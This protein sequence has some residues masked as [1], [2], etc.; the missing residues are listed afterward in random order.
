MTNE[1]LQAIRDRWAVNDQSYAHGDI[2]S[3]LAEIER[4]TAERDQWK[5]G[6]AIVNERLLAEI[7]RLRATLDKISRT[8]C[9]D[10]GNE[11]P[12]LKQFCA[13]L[14]S[15]ALRLSYEPSPIHPDPTGKT[16]EPPHCPTCDCQ[17]DSAAV[18]S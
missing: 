10:P 11:C 2:T 1:Q 16:R 17:T 18:K 8:Y 3:L 12:I 14:A 7:E 6:S 5:L 9:G 15:E 13:H 4:L